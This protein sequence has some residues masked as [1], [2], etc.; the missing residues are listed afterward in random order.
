[1]VVVANLADEPAVGGL[2]RVQLVVILGAVAGPR[3][4]RGQP[5]PR[6]PVVGRF[7]EAHA[8]ALAPE[9]LARVEQP[10]VGEL[11]RS[12]RAVDQAIVA[13]R[14]G[15]ATVGRADHP[16]AECP[17]ALFGG[18]AVVGG[19]PAAE[20]FLGPGPGLAR[21]D[22]LGP[23]EDRL[24]GQRREG[25]DEDRALGGLE[26]AGVAVV[27]RA[28]HHHP[29]PPPRLAAVVA[30]HQLHSAEGTDVGLAPAGTDQQELAA[31]ASGERRP[32]VVEVRLVADHRGLPDFGR[33]RGGR[34]AR[35]VDHRDRS[36]RASAA[37]HLSTGESVFH[38]KAP[39]DPVS[40]C[41][42]SSA[43]RGFHEL[44]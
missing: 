2:H 24:V 20:L 15:H 30:P 44:A 31:A 23:L 8:A 1:L 25:G 39:L 41:Y 22:G 32:A 16:D 18:V 43:S 40:L 37:E 34:A 7:T 27:D 4:Q 11:D 13:A 9:V 21:L 35:A 19:L 42:A 3:G 36:Q 26:H 17:L 5:S 14:E 38:R 29:W 10:A 33:P 6:L 12:V 28:V